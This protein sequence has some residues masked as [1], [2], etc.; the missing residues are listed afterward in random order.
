MPNEL[1]PYSQT[2]LMKRHLAERAPARLTVEEVAITG[3]HNEMWQ[4]PDEL[5]KILVGVVE[6]FEGFADR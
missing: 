3:K 4:S 5:V 6:S 2:E 1:V